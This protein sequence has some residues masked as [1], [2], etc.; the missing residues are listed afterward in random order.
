[1][2]H[3]TSPD[4]PNFPTHITATID[5]DEEAEANCDYDP[6]EGV[7]HDYIKA[8]YSQLQAETNRKKPVAD[9]WLLK[10]L[11]GRIFLFLAEDAPSLC[12]L[13][14]IPPFSEPSYYKILKCGYLINNGTC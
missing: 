10:Y 13:L 6:E 7:M 14:K 1:M 11:K 12:K 2:T 8:I 9:K 5:Y 3:D 4:H